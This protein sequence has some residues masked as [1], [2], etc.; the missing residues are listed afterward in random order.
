M[1]DTIYIELLDESE[2]SFSSIK[3]MIETD[4][5]KMREEGATKE[6]VK[7]KIQAKFLAHF[8][9]TGYNKYLHAYKLIKTLRSRENV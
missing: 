2:P 6:E 5:Y 4:K 3:Q 8:Q 9:S 1:S 7:D